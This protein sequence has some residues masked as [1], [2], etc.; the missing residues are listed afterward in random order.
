M[1]QITT[2]KN[3]TV[4]SGCDY[5]SKGKSARSAC[6]IN[7]IGRFLLA[8][9]LLPI[10]FQL[11]HGVNSS[12]N[13][14]AHSLSD[15]LIVF[16]RDGNIWA[17]RPDGSGEQ[18]I[19]QDGGYFSPA[20][21]PDGKQIA[22]VKES[23]IRVLNIDDYQEKVVVPVE[24][25]GL[26]L[27]NNNFSFHWPKWSPDGQDLY[28]IASDG[29][30]Q[31]DRIRKV[32]VQRGVQVYDIVFHPR[33]LSVSSISS[34]L[35]YTTYNNAPPVIGQGI[36][37][38]NS[39]GSILKPIVPIQDVSILDMCWLW[40]E[41]GIVFSNRDFGGKLSLNIVQIN[42][43]RTTILKDDLEVMIDRLACSPVGNSLAYEADEN[44][45]IY[46]LE[47]QEIKFLTQGIQPSWGLQD[48]VD[49]PIQCGEWE[50][51]GPKEKKDLRIET[52]QQIIDPNNDC[53]G[54]FHL[55]NNT[56]YSV[57]GFSFSG[58]SFELR[59]VINNGSVQ[60]KP[61]G[62]PPLGYVYLIPEQIA[63]LT[64]IPSDPYQDASIQIR[65]NLSWKSLE[66][67]LAFFLL[68]NF[69]DHIPCIPLDK[70]LIMAGNAVNTGVLDQ[71]LEYLLKWPPDFRMASHELD[72]VLEDFWIEAAKDI[73]VECMES[74]LEA[75]GV[76][77]VKLQ[78]ILDANTWWT[79]VI[80]GHYFPPNWGEDAV[81]DLRYTP[82]QI[83]QPTEIIVFQPLSAIGQ[84]ESGS[85]WTLSIASPREGAWRCMVG[86]QIFDPCFSPEGETDYVICGEHPFSSSPGGVRLNLTQPLPELTPPSQTSNVLAMELED[87]TRCRFLTTGT[88]FPV[89]DKYFNYGC[90]DDSILLDVQPGV[91]WTATQ[92]R[93]SSDGQKILETILVKI[94]RVWK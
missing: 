82:A 31:G 78:L 46:N 73:S 90:S 32:D 10:L 76:L 22:Y 47:T 49:E 74:G 48:I 37:I 59:S 30:V 50:W 17:I 58:Y 44:L 81:V 28:F 16:I 26:T 41:S 69:I 89:E 3:K 57:G 64:V 33:G 83:I 75:L 36:D 84:E 25:T 51:I 6:C 39:D 93:I 85:C 13:S 18:Q 38:A 2:C 77:T 43:G 60:W 9:L 20:L 19:T 52:T 14:Y 88:L 61:E 70:V 29:R 7:H 63:A 12:Q 24:K 23:T 66:A 91:T 8:I 1:I 71:V 56:P 53:T 92:A 62:K 80:I 67:D 68:R 11:A 42:Q 45:Y 54:I 79:R 86:N 5:Y 4:Y 21:S 72:S 94:I 87:G 65:G 55:E 40:D 15:G 34:K 27:V 35:A